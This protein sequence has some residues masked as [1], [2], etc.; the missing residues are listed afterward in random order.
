MPRIFI[1]EFEHFNN[2][3]NQDD[4]SVGPKV[5][6]FACGISLEDTIPFDSET[7]QQSP[8]DVPDFAN[9]SIESLQKMAGLSNQDQF[10][11]FWKIVKWWYGKFE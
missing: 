7:S 8:D 5:N 3:S 4:N 1:P 6:D 2:N 11:Y 10:I 9:S